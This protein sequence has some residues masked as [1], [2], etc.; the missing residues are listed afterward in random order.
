M[1]NKKI[2]NSPRLLELKKRRRR[3]KEK[4]VAIA[5][6]ILVLFI[7]GLTYLS[8]INKLNIKNINITGN[9]VIDSNEIKSIVETKLEGKY[10][11]LFPRTNL[12]LYPKNKIKNELETSIKRLY[13]IS[14]TISNLNDLN[15]EVAERQALFTWCG[16]KPPDIFSSIEERCYFLDDTGYIFDEAPFFSAGVYF[17]FYGSVGSYEEHPYGK[18]F[19]SDVFKN[20][21]LFI[22]TVEELKLKPETLFVDDK[23]DIQITLASSKS[24]ANKPKIFLKYDADFNK[25]IENL[26]AAISTDPLKSNIEKKYSSMLYID[27]RYGNKVYFKFE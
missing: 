9:K 10:L 3:A 14:L 21:V 4:K 24:I 12:F 11:G 16:E 15:I 8:R 13:G 17:K 7:T 22:K 19:Y 5:L 2:L 6:V 23:N 25:A 26:Q 18:Y 1:R 27:L 20:L